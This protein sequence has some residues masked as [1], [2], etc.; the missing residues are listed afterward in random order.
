LDAGFVDVAISDHRHDD[1]E[2]YLFSSIKK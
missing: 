1:E 2:M